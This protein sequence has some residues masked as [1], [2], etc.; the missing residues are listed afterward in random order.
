MYTNNISHF[1]EDRFEYIHEEDGIHSEHV[2]D[3]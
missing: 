3:P 1:T 2:K